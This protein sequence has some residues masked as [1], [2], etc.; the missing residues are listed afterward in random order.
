M[1]YLTFRETV[2][3]SAHEYSAWRTADDSC[4]GRYLLCKSIARQSDLTRTT[5]DRRNEFSTWRDCPRDFIRDCCEKAAA[6]DVKNYS[7]RL[8]VNPRDPLGNDFRT[9]FPASWLISAWFPPRGAVSKLKMWNCCSKK[10]IC[11]GWIK[12]LL[13]NFFVLFGYPIIRMKWHQCF[14]VIIKKW[15][16][17]VLFQHAKLFLALKKPQPFLQRDPCRRLRM[18][19]FTNK[20]VVCVYVCSVIRSRYVRVCCVCVCAPLCYCQTSSWPR[21]LIII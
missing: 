5:I 10:S 2:A 9:W 20:Y 1:T 12:I 6:N 15:I 4:V 3:N 8:K 21:A 7:A 14:V 18:E 16:L 19:R 17:L 13:I 11:V